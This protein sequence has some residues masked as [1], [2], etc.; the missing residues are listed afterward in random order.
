MAV[1]EVHLQQLLGALVRDRQGQRIG[2]LEEVRA[3]LASLEP[4]RVGQLRQ[5][6]AAGIDQPP[7]VAPAAVVRRERADHLA[8]HRPR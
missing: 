3:E 5:E 6:P 8:L 1:R 2:R 7:H 4:E